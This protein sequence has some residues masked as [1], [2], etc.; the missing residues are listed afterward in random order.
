MK[1][2][3]Q[4]TRI[5]HKE[6][7]FIPYFLA[8][9]FFFT[10]FTEFALVGI[11]DIVAGDLGISISAVGQFMTAFALAGAIGVPIAFA[12]GGRIGRR[13]MTFISLFVVFL[14][15]CATIFVD[16]YVGIMMCRI[17]LAISS[18]VF[19]VV[20]FVTASQHAPKGKSMSAIST[21]LVGYNAA[22]L[23][24]L[25]LGRL[26]AHHLNWRYVFALFGILTLLSIP[27]A[28]R[29]TTEE[30]TTNSPGLIQQ[31]RLLA[32]KPVLLTWAINLFW[33][34]GYATIYSYIT[35][36]VRERTG[37]GEEVL[38]AILLGFGIATVLGTKFGGPLADK[39]GMRKTLI[40]V[41]ALHILAL[42]ALLIPSGPLMTLIVLMMWGF[43]AWTPSAIIQHAAIIAA[44]DATNMSLSLKN[45][46][47]QLAYALGGALGG[48]IL[49]I[50]ANTELLTAG[51]VLIAIA[52]LLALALRFSGA[53]N[54]SVGS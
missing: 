25:P 16:N 46:S 48:Y 18:G 11:I 44:P 29:I 1:Q 36:F 43:V 47:T 38:S 4:I 30:G 27:Y 33:K 6:R 42:I 35:P 49:H 39:L 15:S 50:G 3:E 13:K 37:S 54:D 23:L 8:L 22:I 34:G 40:A 14:S 53:K 41:L 19:S 21:L 45:T 17:V 7:I 51:L 32:R 26:L 31:A 2:T 28:L 52:L 12:L 5:G 24:G 9:V 10:S 20:A